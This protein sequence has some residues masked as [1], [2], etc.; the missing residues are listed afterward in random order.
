MTISEGQEPPLI[1]SIQSSNSSAF[2]DASDHAQAA[3]GQTAAAKKR[4][5]FERLA[6]HFPPGQFI[7]YIVV[8]VWNTAFGYS[9]FA[10]FYYLIHRHNI[11]AAYVYAQI[12]AAFI[13]VSVAFLGYKW[14]VF[15]TKG[16]YL[17]EW[18][19]GMA[20]Y[21]SSFLPALLMLPL[22]IKALEY[23]LHLKG[24]A[25]YI[26]NALLTGFSVIYSFIGHKKI[27][28]RVPPEQEMSES[29]S[30]DDRIA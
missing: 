27:T 9:T 20:V 19:K 18:L 23:G 12:I 11:P 3:Q 13:N 30:T 2:T 24:S 21:G 4:L 15:K 8:G 17:R 7:R 1:E 25:P 6:S 10:A 5:R 22:L 16:N 14:F 28:F 29:P 26:A